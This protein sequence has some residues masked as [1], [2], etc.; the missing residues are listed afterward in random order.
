M[1]VLL[2]ATNRHDRLQ[3]RMN[4]QPMPIGL[5]YIAGHLDH[6]RHEV[7]VLDLMFSEDHLTDVENAVKEFQ[8]QMVGM[9]VRNLSNH[10]Y[11]NTIWALPISKEVIDRIR[12]VS[13][14]VIVC[15]GPAFSILPKE[16]YEFLGADLGLAGDAGETFAALA[17]S[18][19]IGEPDYHSL[20]GLVYRKD[21][22]VHQNE[23]YCVSAFAQSPR[24]EDLDMA[25]YNKAGFGIGILS[26]LGGF[27]Y[28]ANASQAQINESGW[29]VIRPIDEVVAEV[30]DMKERFG[31]KKV[32]FVDNGFNLPLEHAK[33]LCRALIDSDAGVRWNTCL[34]PFNCDKE[35]IS[36]MKEAGCGLVMMTNRSGN[37]DDIASMDEENDA[38]LEVCRM[39]EEGDLHYNIGKIFGE[40]GETRETVE[41]KLDFLRSINPA[42]ANLRVG[43]SVMPGT[44]VALAA[45]REGLIK[46]ESELVKPTF[47]IADGVKDW[48]VDYL[49]EQTDQNPRWN[50]S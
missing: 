21:G 13:D 14:A 6:D 22:Q 8:P 36:L 1:R 47:Y 17:D 18:L 16:C 29:R 37:P 12:S 35:L 49:K 26:K 23:G 43:V 48:I 46:D 39:C 3:S 45:K 9:S 25:R 10:S 7:K 20:P 2:I 34:A 44:E 11:M 27:Y 4:A 30:K 40:P 28:P 31:M 42:M 38:L 24:L 19:E 15:G 33:S 32:F 5:A 50:L 41:H